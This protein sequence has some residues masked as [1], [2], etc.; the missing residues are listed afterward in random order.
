MWYVC[1]A[2]CQADDSHVMSRIISSENY[3]EHALKMSSVGRDWSEKWVFD[4]DSVI[5]KINEN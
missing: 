2:G 4:I 3:I 1:Q 5:K